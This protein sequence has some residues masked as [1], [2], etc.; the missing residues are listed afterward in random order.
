VIGSPTAYVHRRAAGVSL[1]V[2]LCEEA[3]A[4]GEGSSCTPVVLHWGADLG[5]LSDDDVA[6]MVWSRTSKPRDS[7]VDQMRWVSLLPQSSSGFTGTPAVE[8]ARSRSSG[9][10]QPSWRTWELLETTDGL[11]LSA[12][13]DECQLRVLIELQMTEEGLVRARSTLTNTAEDEVTVGALRLVL[14]VGSEATE[15]LDLTGRWTRERAPQ[16]SPYLQG[17]W[18]RSGRH[19]RTG[20]DATLVLVAGTAN[21]SFRTGTVWGVHLAWSGDHQHYAERTPEGEAL[22]GAQEL[23]GPGEINL[24]RDE[25]YA[26][27]WLN[28]SWSADGLDAMSARLHHWHRRTRSRRLPPRPVVVNTWEAVYFDHELPRLTALVDAAQ[29]VGAERFVLDDGW[30]LGR[31]ND[32]AGLGDWVVDPDV[33]PDGLHPLIEH[34]HARD[35]DF[36]LWVE[37]EMV[38]VDSRLARQHPEWLLKG[39]RSL[40]LDWRHQQVLDLQQSGAFVRVRDSLLAL[41]DEYDIAFVKWDHNRDVLDAA[42]AGRPAMHGQTRAFYQL[43]DEIRTAHPTLEI[44]TCASGGGRVDLGVLARTDR[45]WPS[46]TIDAVERQHIQRWT[47]LLVPPELIG[48]HVGGPVAHTTGRS[49][50]LDFRAATALLGHFGIEWDLSTVTGEELA[51]LREWVTLHKELRHLVAEGVSVHGDHPDPALLITGAVS[52]DGHEA[53]FVVAAVASSA[54]QLPLPVVLPGLRRDL[55]YAVRRVGAGSA[56]DEGAPWLSSGLTLPGTALGVAGVRL[57]GLRPDTAVVLHCRATRA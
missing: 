18:S 43:L 32:S 5:P 26:T 9:A 14:P 36:G 13:D 31:R 40:P 52:Q 16:R 34:V 11:R 6:H 21:F 28:G 29:K 54:T 25:S 24:G 42:H 35:M 56:D 50:H 27:P 12:G 53:V 45:V 20:H 47:T 15:L 4:R 57:P 38:N 1:L 37:P 22:L 44:E 39:R 2:A 49:H 55:R 46:D 33:W 41:L 7:A 8:T 17:T 51:R 23:L 19:G 48:T 3:D 30:F 10:W